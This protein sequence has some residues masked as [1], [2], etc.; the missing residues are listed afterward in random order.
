MFIYKYY[1][2]FLQQCLQDSKF[3]ILLVPDVFIY[4]YILV[5][6]FIIFF[7]IAPS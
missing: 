6:F 5:I 1:I 3:I 4:L 2:S 7:I